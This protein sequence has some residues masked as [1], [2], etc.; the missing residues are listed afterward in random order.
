MIAR[1]HIALTVCLVVTGCSSIGQ[2]DGPRIKS[3]EERDLKVEREVIEQG[4]RGKA[5]ESY[6]DF[7]EKEENDPLR[8][9]AMR[10][11]ADLQ[12]EKSEAEYLKK[13]KRLENRKDGGEKLEPADY[14]RAIQTYRELLRNHPDYAGNDHVLYQLSRA[15]EQ[16]GDYQQAIHALDRLIASYPSVAFMDEVQFRLGELHF[17]LKSFRDAERAYSA[18]LRFGDTS[19][20]YERAFYKQGWSLFKQS[21]YKSALDS[22]FGF[23]DRKFTDEEPETPTLTQGERELMDDTFRVVSLSFSYLGGEKWITKYFKENGTRPYVATVYENLGALYLNQER[24]VDA[25]NAFNEFISQYANDHRAPLF[26]LKVIET[27]RRG[28]FPS[29]VLQA[30]ERF[31]VHYGVKSKFWSLHSEDTHASVAPHLKS[32]IEDLAQHFHAQA[33][34]T[35]SAADYDQAARWYSEFVQAFSDDAKAPKINFLLAETL[36]EAGRY[37]DAAIE[38]ERTAYAYAPHIG[39]AEA[40]YAALLAHKQHEEELDESERKKYQRRTIASALRFG[41]TFPRDERTAAVLTNAAEEL[42]AL[43]E[44]AQA[45]TTARRVIAIRPRP[46]V[47]LRRTA[48]IVVAHAEFEQQAFEPAETAYK[49]ALRLT[50][51]TDPQQSGLVDRLASSV[52]KQGD[53]LRAAGDLRAAVKHFLRVEKVAPAS[54]VVPTAEYDAAAALIALKDWRSAVTVLEG[55]REKFPNHPLQRD[56][57]EKLAAA[58]LE[59]EQWSR[60][61]AAFEEIADQREDMALRQAALWQAAELYEKGEREDW[62]AE[63]Y[64]RF[65]RLFPDSFEQAME[66]RNRLVQL[67][68]GKKQAAEYYHWLR[69]IVDAADTGRMRSTDRM[70]YLTSNAAFL[71]AERAYEEFRGV[72]LLIP[73][74]QSLSEKKQKMQVALKGYGRVV[75]YGVAEFTTA[76]TFRIAEIYHSLSRDLLTSERPKGLSALELEQYDV[77]LEEQAYP[78][79]EK[80]I[81]IHETNVRRVAD[82]VYDE[83]VKK[84]FE[85]LSKLRPVRYAKFERSQF[86]SDAIQ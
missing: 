13:V 21:R 35:K 65:I 51:R 12:L 74:K 86:A 9:E 75:D 84:S 58:Y 66:A 20:F 64:K 72:R 81:E 41:D 54:S 28:G 45:A 82:N 56:I 53:R 43:S 31:V 63:A 5:I 44:F 14:S 83:W 27:Y 60:A 42:F 29:L 22:F 46:D 77:L 7:L 52:Y 30:K 34:K 1:Q 3:I 80:A 11:L 32:N 26:Q 59:G 85:Q 23:L 50:S 69:Q 36:F 33:Q 76:A 2:D 78:F 16:S 39:S 62:A 18:V 6:R 70:R 15:F 38:Y 17:L 61:A 10:R 79:E 67:Y 4:G 8:A 55:L 49:S 19:L 73:L 24:Y 71:L 68:E 40:G 57:P 37:G 25:A 48:W 47:Q